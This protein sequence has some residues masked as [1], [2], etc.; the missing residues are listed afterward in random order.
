MLKVVNEGEKI[1]L[2]WMFKSAGTNAVLHLYK[3]D[4]TPVDTSTV[5]NFTASTFGGYTPATLTRANWN[6]SVTNA[7]G[8]AEIVYSTDISWTSSTS[9][10]VIGYYVVDTSG[11]LLFAEKFAQA[12]AL[13]DGD[14]LTISPRFTLRSEA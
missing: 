6:N 3:N 10:T 5:A 4:Y 8:K 11:A 13:V 12:R 2:N 7:A 9:E 14:S 1:L